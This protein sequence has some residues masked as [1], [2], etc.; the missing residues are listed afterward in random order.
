VLYLTVAAAVDGVFCAAVRSQY[1]PK[2]DL[3]KPADLPCSRPAPYKYERNLTMSVWNG[4]AWVRPPF[5]R[6]KPYATSYKDANKGKA[7]IWQL[8]HAPIKGI[9]PEMVRW[10]W[11]NMDKQVAD[12]R[13]GKKWQV[14]FE[15]CGFAVQN[16]CS[17]AAVL[18]AVLCR[19]GKG[20]AACCSR[21]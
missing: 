7:V 16:D 8:R 1:L 5:V 19:T 20:E 9:T 15:N 10:M 4:T 6:N 14:R 2:M 11:K 3:D 17:C 13:D 21:R 18:R 12:P